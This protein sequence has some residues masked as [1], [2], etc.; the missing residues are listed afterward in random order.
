MSVNK[1]VLV[2][3]LGRDPETRY[4]SNG[5]AVVNFSMATDENWKDKDGNRQQK[6]EWHNIVMFR[7]LAE[8]AAQYLKKGQLVYIEGKIQSRKY[9]GKDNIERTAY[10]IVANEM[11]MLGSRSENSG[12]SGYSSFPAEEDY[13][14]NNTPASSDIPKPPNQASAPAST[15]EPMEDIDNDIPF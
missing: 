12:G 2:G 1:V 9:T 11:K 15:P 5:D 4:M 8:I 3:R 10:D 13:A 7:R 6:T 14:T